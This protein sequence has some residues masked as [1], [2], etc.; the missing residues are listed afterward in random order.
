MVHAQRIIHTCLQLLERKSNCP[1]HMKYRRLLDVTAAIVVAAACC[2]S[3]SCSCSYHAALDS[4][5][6][7]CSQRVHTFLSRTSQVFHT[8]KPFMVIAHPR[9]LRSGRSRWRK[10]S[11]PK[12]QERLRLQSESCRRSKLLCASG[13]AKHAGSPRLVG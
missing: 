4:R 13:Q 10:K 1:L 11:Q 7:A 9:L 8:S 12:S 3:C 2:C 5:S 6:T